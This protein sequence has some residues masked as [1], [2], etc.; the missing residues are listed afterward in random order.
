M[1]EV[2]RIVATRA[3]A[4]L[5]QLVAIYL[6]G[7]LTHDLVFWWTSQHVAGKPYLSAIM[8]PI[9][10]LALLGSL[11]GMLLMM[12]PAV[13]ETEVSRGGLASRFRATA[14]AL[15]G[16]VLPFVAFYSAWHYLA[17]DW[18]GYLYDAFDASF[19]NTSEAFT[20]PYLIEKTGLTLF[21]AGVLLSI[22]LVL[23]RFRS[24]LPA[25]TVAAEFYLEAA[26]IYLLIGNWLNALHV[27]QWVQSRQGVVW[28]KDS[29]GHVASRIPGGDVVWDALGWLISEITGVLVV[30]LGWLTLA[31]VVYAL[32]PETNWANARRV[33]LGSRRRAAAIERLSNKPGTRLLAWPF[34]A[35][36][37]A[38][39][40][41]VYVIFHTGA[42]PMALYVFVYTCLGW[43]F[44]N[45]SET[46]GK[47]GWLQRGI[48]VLLGPH[49]AEWWLGVRDALRIVP[50]TT[51]AVLQICLITSVYA[52]YVRGVRRTASE[53]QPV[54]A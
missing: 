42:I 41:A 50:D 34:R 32:V 54:A 46:P 21:I 20:L 49:E 11:A 6:A 1:L 8:L 17:N 7:R 23:K 4:V 10:M 22:R 33:L 44:G 53:F 40:D 24:R 16:A 43:L 36:A 47:P 52:L 14:G 37:T 35:Q 5:P 3:W 19:V 9:G 12:R 48:S 13:A 38:I 2:L 27:K 29:V 39:R 30:P 26:W 45:A 28:F 31:G 15:T 18:V 25:W 51:F